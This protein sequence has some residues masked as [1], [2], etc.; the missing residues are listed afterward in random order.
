MD[1][2]LI[3][4]LKT[5]LEITIQSFLLQSIITIDP[6]QEGEIFTSVGEPVPF[7]HRL[8]PGSRLLGC[9]F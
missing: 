4:E 2:Q 1:I 6:E 3:L 9:R 8:R 5:V 7:F